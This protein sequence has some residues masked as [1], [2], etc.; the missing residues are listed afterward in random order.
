MDQKWSLADVAADAD[1]WYAVVDS[2]TGYTTI[3]ANFGGED[4]TDNGNDV[5]INSR[6][7]CITAKWNQGY[8]T[9]DG[10]TIMRGCGPKTIDFWMTTAEAMYGAIAT[11]GGYYW[12]MENCD[13]TQCR[14]VAIDFGNGS[15]KQEMK[16][17]GEPGM[18]A[19]GEPELYGY[20]I[21][22]NNNV[23]DNGTN[24]MMAYRGAYTE[25]YN[26]S[27]SNNN[28]LN[29]GL[30][31]EAYIK[32]VSGGWGINIHD[33]YL[34]SDQAW[35]ARPIW[36]DCE[37]DGSIVS[38]NII[39]DANAGFT[40][41]D[42]EC[43]AGWLMVSNNVLIGVGW[44]TTLESH[45]YFVN[46]LFLNTPT[47]NRTWNSNGSTAMAGA[48]GYDGYS[49]AMRIAEPGTLNM[50]GAKDT[51]RFET[52]NRYNKLIGNIFF[53]N[54]PVAASS[55]GN[56][57]SECAPKD[58]I[59][60]YTEA[61]LNPD[62]SSNKDYSGGCWKDS[63]MNDLY[64]GIMAWIPVE[65]DSSL[66]TATKLYGNECDYNVYYGGAEKINQQYATARSYEADANSIE[67][68]G[69][70]YTIDGDAESI[71][72]TLTVDSSVTDVEA[73]AITGSYLGAASCYQ[74]E[75]Y[76]WY[77][78]D[79]DT[80][81]FGNERDS[82][83]TVVGPFA[84]LKTGIN[85][86]KLWPAEGKQALTS[87][88]KSV[89]EVEDWG[90]TVTKVIVDLGTTVD[91]GTVTTDTFNVHVVRSDSRN[92]D[93]FVEEGDRKVVKSYIS[94]AEGNPADSGSYATLELEIGPT[95][96]LGNAL[97]TVGGFNAFIDCNYTITQ[98]KDIK[99]GATGISGLIADQS[100]GVTRVLVDEFETDG[101]YTLDDT[102]L[103]YASYAPPSDT[104]KNPLIIWLHGS[105]GGGMDPAVPLSS[106]KV[107]DLASDTV[108]NYFGGAYVLVPQTPGM[109]MNGEDGAFGARNS[110]YEEALMGLIK[111]YVQN[112]DDIDMSRVYLMG[113][114]NGGYMTMVMI[115][116]Y[117]G[118][119]A[120]AVPVCEAL[121]DELITDDDISAY[122]GMSIWL[123]CAKTD[124]TVSVNLYEEPTY[125]R[126]I[127]A[128]ATDVYL[129]EF[130]NVSDTSG[131]YFQDDE[132][133]AYEY[134]GH[135]SWTYLFN[136]LV[137][138]EIEGVETSVY[139]W[140]AALTLDPAISQW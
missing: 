76:E 54:G 39:Y 118:Y 61:Y 103:T 8:I 102:T 1:T 70:S 98:Q 67:V 6:M 32:D 125:A 40:Y 74:Q 140:A 55:G 135:W 65:S 73:P 58:F 88:Y 20:H 111:E 87:T 36:L 42:L 62:T 95:L 79:V 121:K 24:G 126:L 127:A 41:I 7:Q 51:S 89:V 112:N 130:D 49:R 28:A 117:P 4:P 101:T 90:A 59:G 33:N 107:C 2:D 100:A 60:V 115:R 26:N 71:S 27:L 138:E 131:L 69:G 80:D 48:E 139:Q 132:V 124:A 96:T 30:L 128:G 82:A 5:E 114:S 110:I 17:E 37:C 94:D 137:S 34:Y 9:I 78:P 22:R 64:K 83:N 116:D 92:A 99:S 44:G 19:F 13:V 86:Y 18:K 120:A 84:D 29:T 123:I 45:A 57:L 113:A 93:P 81:F 3:Y 31:S 91:K 105:A 14:G 106:N 63:A 15:G 10:F 46:N 97:N 129:N 35:S 66:G 52:Y 21:I 43:N 104:D 85:T 136:D 56:V 134:N 109:W 77:S 50:I 108:Q 122:K 68:D 133:T 11:N 75:G 72:I 12:I 119:F 47:S 16:H 38:N 53:D 25:I 23:H